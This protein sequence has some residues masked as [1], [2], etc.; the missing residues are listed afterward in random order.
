MDFDLW[1]W[2]TTFNFN[3]ANLSDFREHLYG[4]KYVKIKG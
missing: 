3:V 1:L 4:D 2:N